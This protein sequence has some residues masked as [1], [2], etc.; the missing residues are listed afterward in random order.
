LLD[1]GLPDSYGLE[2]F[3]KMR[4]AMPDLPVIVLTGIDD[5]DLAVAAVRDGAQDYL[6][7]GQVGGSLL[8]RAAR[9][10]LERQKAAAA[11]RLG[12]ERLDLVLEAA[13]MGAWELNL[14]DD[15]A[16]RTLSHDQIFGYESLLPEWGLQQFISHVD[17]EDGMRVEKSFGDATASGRLSFECRIKRADGTVCWI[18]VAGRTYC[19]AAGN[20]V[21]M[22]GTI[23]DITDRKRAEEALRQQTEELRTRNKELTM[24]NRVTVGR[25]LRMIELKQE[26]NE[27]CRRLGEPPLHATNLPPAG[28]ATVAAGILPAVSGGFQPRG[29]TPTK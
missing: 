2:T 9:Y 27:L 16:W 4:K 19:D 6:V 28:D 7:K 3:H 8:V 11:N 13:Q 5:Q 18:A 25:E 26:V 12:K 10:A 17:P 23:L 29:G 20:P 15:T 24:F 1:L 22:M 14:V 21:R